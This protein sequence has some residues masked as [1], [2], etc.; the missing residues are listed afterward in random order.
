MEQDHPD[1]RA[2]IKGGEQDEQVCEKSPP[3]F[4]YILDGEVGEQAA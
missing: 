1:A 4:I 2:E 3:S